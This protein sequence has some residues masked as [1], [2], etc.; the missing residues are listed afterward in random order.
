MEE[1]YMSAVTT[2]IDMAITLFAVAISV[3]HLS[4]MFFGDS[5]F[6]SF[7]ERW[8]V[9]ATV[10]YTFFVVWNSYKSNA[11]DFIAQGK[12]WLIIPVIIGLLSFTRLTRFRWA[13]RYPVAAL[14]GIGLGVFFGFNLRGSIIAIVTSTVDE[15]ITLQPDPFSAIVSFIAVVSVV[16]YYLYSERYST[17]FHSRSGRLYYV[18]RLGRLFMMASFGYL[19]GYVGVAFGLGILTSFF[20]VVIKRP[21]ETLLA[22]IAGG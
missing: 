6:S 4:M 7:G 11:I 9:G 5:F 21:I 13:A 22:F 10:G 18:M 14:S 2:P 17:I 8:F 16:T 3:G 12:W 20:T 1:C 15:L 19:L